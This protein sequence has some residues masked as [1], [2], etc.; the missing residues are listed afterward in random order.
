LGSHEKGLYKGPAHSGLFKIPKKGYY[1][2]LK[3]KGTSK[4]A[5]FRGS[6]KANPV[7]ILYNGIVENNAYVF[8]AKHF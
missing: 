2:S 4:T 7:E 8:N 3:G 1:S 6:L 5:V